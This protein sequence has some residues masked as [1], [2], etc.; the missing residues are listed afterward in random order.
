MIAWRSAVNGYV[1][2]LNKRWFEY[3][4]STPEQVR[5]RRWKN[6]VHPDDLEKLVNI[7]IEYVAS[8]IPI[9]SR[10]RLRRFDGEYRWFLFRPAPV[11]DEAGN[12]V[13]WYGTITDIEE[14]KQA[15]DALAASERSLNL[16]INTVPA[17]V[18]SARTD[19]TAEFFNQHYLDYIGFTSEQA[20][21]WGWA[22]A[23]HPDDLNGLA[24]AWQA[25][26]ASGESGKAEARLRR[27]DGEYRW[28]LFRA[29]PLRD[30]SKRVVKWFG[31]N[32]DVEDIKRAEEK[33]A[34]AERELQRTIDNIPVMVAT[35]G[36]DGSRISI[37]KQIQE[38]TGHFSAEEWREEIHPDDVELGESTWRACVSRGE[39]F[40]LEYRMRR[41]DGL[42]R[43]MMRRRVPAYDEAGRLTKWYGIGYEIEDRKHA[44][45]AITARERDLKLIIDTIPALAWSASA[46]GTADFL[47]QHYLDYLGYT[48][49]Q[50]QGRGW[51]AALHPDDLNGL[52]A[53]W[54]AVMASGKVGET[55]ARL[56]R[57]DGQYRWFLLRANPLRDESGNIIKWYGL[58]T[59]IED[60]KRAD[61]A[62]HA[63]RTELAHMSRVMSLGALTASI[64]HEVNQPLSGIITNAN[65]C[66]RML[67]ADPPNVEGARETARRTLRDGNRASEVVTRLRALFSKREPK[68][69]PID[70]NDATAEVIALSL[71]TLQTNRV[72]LNTDLANDL[73]VI[74]GD[75][76][77][78]QQ[79]I[80][81]LV[82]N[83]T[84]AMTAVDDRPR[85]LVIG[86]KRDEGG[87]V[88]LSI[89]DA[90]VG[91]DPGTV[92]RLFESFY[93]TKRD[94]MGMGLSVSRSIIENHNGRLWAEPNEGPG[95]TFFFAV[96]PLTEEATAESLDAAQTPRGQIAGNLE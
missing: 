40:E 70:L 67:G 6:Y 44:E 27:R 63:A 37:N 88:R 80:F 3:T 55:E 47:N 4:G 14:L 93:T 30:G 43:W 72:I 18:W 53:T 54:Q 12:R 65:T 2:W 74:A 76:V 79:V 89:E 17:L 56:R 85:R 77:Q 41:A 10:A 9:E 38:Y 57:F 46:D 5:G 32:T 87:C 48:S 49:E 35:Y 52:V 11:H 64:A 68:F 83:A 62:L 90:G 69:E 71:N 58:N 75:R 31:V 50:A 28:F 94:G 73:P 15:E 13:A 91:L 81:N 19:G 39:P 78:L 36:A 7:G 92:D 1:Q 42:Y 66:L 51:R 96:P 29:S 34:E 25:I 33:A 59:D 82:Q 22:A 20:Q 24:A 95:A 23:V 84:D 61:E 60:R 26:M 16:T 21:G 45:D 86:T 8:G